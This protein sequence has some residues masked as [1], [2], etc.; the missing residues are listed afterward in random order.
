MASVPVA[1][2]D[3]VA[4]GAGVGEGAA[5]GEEHGC[6]G[7]EQGGEAAGI[8]GNE[9]GMVRSRRLAGLEQVAQGGGQAGDGGP[10]ELA[11]PV[12]GGLLGVE[13][14]V[15]GAGEA[16]DLLGCAAGAEPLGVKTGLATF[17]DQV[18]FLGF[19][20]AHAAALEAIIAG[21][22]G[23]LSRTF[24]STHPQ[25]RGIDKRDRLAIVIMRVV[26]HMLTAERAPDILLDQT[27]HT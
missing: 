17:D 22:I 3:A 24:I 1:Q 23:R 26:F 16:G 13:A 15:E 19:F 21:S 4:A 14:F 10:V 27:L 5:I 25:A 20:G 9:A 18:D 6:A 11:Q 8:A 12:G 7:A 2:H